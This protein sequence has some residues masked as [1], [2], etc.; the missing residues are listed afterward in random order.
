MRAVAFP[1]RFVT[2]AIRSSNTSPSVSAGSGID[3]RGK[4]GGLGPELVG[5]DTAGPRLARDLVPER[6]R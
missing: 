3:G 5:V 2:E 4:T 1:S 6:R